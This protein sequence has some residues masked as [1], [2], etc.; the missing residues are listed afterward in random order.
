MGR[1]E[2]ARHRGCAP[3]AVAKA[4][5]S[6]RIK[7]AVVYDA[8]GRFEGIRWQQA[9]VLWAQNTDPLEA[10]RNGKFYD[11]PTPEQS[12]AAQGNA[13]AAGSEMVSHPPSGVDGIS[14]AEPVRERPTQQTLV[15]AA[16]P[17]AVVLTG[18]A[19]GELDL[20]EPGPAATQKQSDN[21]SYLQA[22]AVKEQF[23][24]KS[25]QVAYLQTIGKLVEAT[26]VYREM[27]E[28]LIQLKSRI[29]ASHES[30][31]QKLAAESDPARITRILD[32]ESRR[33]FDECSRHF[34][35]DA[36]G[37]AEESA[38]ACT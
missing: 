30:L 33:V 38:A 28:I 27:Q 7:A 20:G 18:P 34:A 24:A 9:D 13:A 29:R 17:G 4:I 14:D 25:A 10:A 5:S 6:G 11:A 1:N 12:A 26:A 22:R 35:D 8:A 21:E 19:A 2:Y 36:A 3:N 32:D 15:A 23:A 31:A 37:G 16:V